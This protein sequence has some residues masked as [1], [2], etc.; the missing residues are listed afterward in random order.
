M[1]TDPSFT[2][3]P[4][5]MYTDNSGAAYTQPVHVRKTEVKQNSA[6]KKVCP[7]HKAPH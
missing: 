1:Y 3:T 6:D 5:P 7:I 2:F 4:A